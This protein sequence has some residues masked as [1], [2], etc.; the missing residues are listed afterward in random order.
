MKS[1]A[2]RLN[3]RWKEVNTTIS[4]VLDVGISSPGAGC[5]WSTA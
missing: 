1:Q 3:P 5:H 2:G 4:F